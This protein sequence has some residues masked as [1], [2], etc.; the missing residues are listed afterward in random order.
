[1]I[2]FMRSLFG[3]NGSS[4]TRTVVGKE[5][6][7]DSREVAFIRD[8]N[9]RLAELLNLHKK[10]KGT[11][12]EEKIK[13]VYEKTKKIHW[14]LVSKKRFHELELF[15]IRNTDHFTNTYNLI[16]DIHQRH[17]ESV[18][19]TLTPEQ[20]EVEEPAPLLK[21]ASNG[22]GRSK[23]ELFDIVEKAR[24]KGKPTKAAYTDETGAVV[25]SL[26]IPE[27]SINPIAK[28]FYFKEDSLG[29]QVP[30][31]ISFIS[32][33]QEKD[34][35]QAYVSERLGIKDIYYVGNARINI[36]HYVSAAPDEMVPVVYLRNYLYA[37]TLQD[38][39]LFPVKI[40]RKTT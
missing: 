18:F 15:H 29:K 1:M 16:I 38:Y 30:Y 14:F 27:V 21:S 26:S 28:V 31:E 8:S 39:R 13:S 22:N 32:T 9:S 24:Q 34:A 19:N 23:G 33:Q 40:N 17:K 35:F 20:Q 4:S 25:S 2:Q 3:L 10:Y 37:L 5:D 36:P 7:F 12:H 11:L 6:S